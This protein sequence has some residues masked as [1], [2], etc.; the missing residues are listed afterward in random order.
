[1]LDTILFDMGGTLEDIWYN[2]ETERAVTKALMDMLAQEGLAVECDAAAFWQKLKN[3]VKAYKQWSL[4]TMLEKKPEEIWP[5]YYLR[6]F[7]FPAEAIAGMA[8]RLAQT[9]ET[10]HYH[11]E[12]RPHVAETLEALHRRGYRLGVISNTASLYSVFNV[13]EEYGI[14][15]YFADVTLSSVTGYRKPHPG[16]FTVATRQMCARPESCLYV[17][18]TVSRDVVGARRAGFSKV[19]QIASFMTEMSDAEA[20]KERYTADYIMAGDFRELVDY[21][22]SVSRQGRTAQP[23]G[24]AAHL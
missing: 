9:W 10:V 12:L 11:R 3:G 18:D 23:A 1:M 8:E 7:A 17:G 24:S 14:R 21:V 16:I 4:D 15:Q 6:E 2:D 19:V 22:E 5:Q 13:L 20:E